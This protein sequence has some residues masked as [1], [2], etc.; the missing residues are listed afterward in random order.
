MIANACQWAMILYAANPDVEIISPP[1]I[2]VLGTI[3]FVVGMVDIWIEI[4]I[5]QMVGREAH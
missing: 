2:L 3:T 1:I 5:R 4:L